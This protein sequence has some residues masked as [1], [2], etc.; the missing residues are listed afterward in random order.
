MIKEARKVGLAYY[1]ACDNPGLFQTAVGD[2]G[3]LILSRFP[4]IES[5]FYG[6]KTPALLSDSLAYKGVL[7]AKIDVG[8]EDGSTLQVFSTHV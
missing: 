6:F 1:T 4:I 7:Y 3:L 8:A 5:E 2:G